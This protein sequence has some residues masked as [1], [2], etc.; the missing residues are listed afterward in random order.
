MSERMK[1]WKPKGLFL[2]TSTQRDQPEAHPDLQTSTQQAM[3]SLLISS[4]YHDLLP[5]PPRVQ[6]GA[7]IWGP[8][9]HAGTSSTAELSNPPRVLRERRRRRRNTK[10]KRG[11]GLR[12]PNRLDAEGN[13]SAEGHKQSAFQ[14]KKSN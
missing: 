6:T 2:L 3:L 9:G 12:A 8:C 1:K 13:M 4:H 14:R 11:K 10:E 7:N 5:S